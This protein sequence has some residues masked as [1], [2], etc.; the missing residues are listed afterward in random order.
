M[1]LGG[2]LYKVGILLSLSLAGLS[3]DFVETG[4]GSFRKFPDPMIDYTPHERPEQ[5]AV[6]NRCLNEIE[7]TFVLMIFEVCELRV[8]A[9]NE[10][11]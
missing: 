1:C 9:R 7:M 6:Y 3:S 2:V 10:E 8:S 4:D 11:G 5:I